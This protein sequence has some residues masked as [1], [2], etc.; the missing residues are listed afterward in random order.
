MMSERSVSQWILGVMRFQTIFGLYSWVCIC[1]TSQSGE[2][3]R[4]GGFWG[5]SLLC[6]PIHQEVKRLT[7]SLGGES[8]LF[9]S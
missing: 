1:R 9:H 3:V 5:Y 8:M 4:P 6:F 2:K 7:F